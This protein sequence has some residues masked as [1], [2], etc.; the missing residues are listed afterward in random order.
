MY[1]VE[2]KVE[3]DHGP[4]T[5][6]LSSIGAEYVGT[7][8]QEDTYYN[9]PDRDF[10]ETDEALRV[11]RETETTGAPDELESTTESF[12]TYKGPL[13]D[14]QS[15]TRQEAETRVDSDE[16]IREILTGLQYEP[17]ATVRKERER[18]TVEDCLVTLDS[19]DGLGEFVEVETET[20]DDIDSARA[21]AIAVLESLGLDPDNQ[22]QT[23]Y[24]GLLLEHSSE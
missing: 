20:D 2:V 19:V 13:L 3:A 22:T 23:S 12:L 24:L 7:V 21:E 18:Y 17:A 15:K 9:A 8:I 4:I 16:A 5:D 6:R 10:V 14:D 1:E 11:R